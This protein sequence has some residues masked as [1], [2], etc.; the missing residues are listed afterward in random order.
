M[1]CRL[2][3]ADGHW[4]IRC[5]L[6]VTLNGVEGNAVIAEAADTRE[7]VART[8]DLMPDIALLDLRLPGDGGLAALRQI[9]QQRRSQKVV[10]MGDGSIEHSVREALRAG[11]DG[12]VRRDTSPTDLLGSVRSVRE[13]SV[14]LDAEVSR[15]M[16]LADHRRETQGQFGPLHALSAREY[17]VFNLVGAGFTNRATAERLQL[18]PKTVEKYRAAVMQKLKLRSAVDLRLLAMQLS[19]D[20]P[21]GDPGLRPASSVMAPL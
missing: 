11:C 2:L 21:P 3:V 14:Y 12:Y 5:G 8:I 10:L 7:A 1:S 18:S 20:S 9:K 19:G 13:G 4:L 15:Q 17:A 6:R 16:I